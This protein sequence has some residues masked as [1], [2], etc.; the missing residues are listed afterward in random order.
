MML[1]DKG[2]GSFHDAYGVMPGFS[3]QPI[4]FQPFL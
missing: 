4:D 2:A 1:K 3:A